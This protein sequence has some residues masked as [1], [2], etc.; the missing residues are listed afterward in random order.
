MARVFNFI[1]CETGRVSMCTRIVVEV[2]FACALAVEIEL[3]IN[4]SHLLSKSIRA[5]IT[6]EALYLEYGL[7]IL[8]SLQQLL[9]GP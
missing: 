5:G 3:P 6:Q 1:A 8:L 2:R 4:I 7:G 9:A